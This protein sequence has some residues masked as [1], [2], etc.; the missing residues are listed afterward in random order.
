V[1]PWLWRLGSGLVYVE[2][3]PDGRSILRPGR[4]PTPDELRADAERRERQAFD[5]GP[6]MRFE[7]PPETARQRLR[8]WHRVVLEH[9]VERRARREGKGGR[10]E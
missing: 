4:E 7:A 9:E 3:L 5:C 6:W 10:D 8:R 2:E 1:S